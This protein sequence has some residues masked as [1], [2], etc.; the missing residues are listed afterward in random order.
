MKRKILFVVADIT[1]VGGIERVITTLANS[2]NTNKYEISI[3]S[4]Y[5]S[6][7]ACNYP[8]SETIEVQFLTDNNYSGR[9]G[10]MSR[11]VG[12]LKSISL[13]KRFFKKNK[14]DK[15]ISNSFPIT[16]CIVLSGV[17]DDILSYEHV[18]YGYYSNIVNLVRKIIYRKVSKIICLTDSDLSKYKSWHE[19]VIR[20]YNPSWLKSN[21]ISEKRFNRI[22]AVGRLEYQKGFDVLVRLFKEVDELG[23]KLDI[24]GVG[25]EKDELER[26][27]NQNNIKNIELKGK[28]NDIKEEYIKSDFLVMSSRFEGF[29]MVLVEAMECGLPCL[30]FDCPTGPS[31]II[32]HGFNGYLVKLGDERDFINR[33]IELSSNFELRNELGINA[34]KST[35]KFKIE[36]IIKQWES[37]LG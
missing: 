6:N 12:L 27:I 23:V 30:S 13:L 20:I 34:K 26:I 19:S 29:G 31:D 8:L 25:S 4:I 15:I 22:I 33:L 11:M 1:Y 35:E 16:S 28:T 3:L 2:F 7:G 24:Y 32:D 36:R 21:I 14:F 37:V 10:S 5:N 17:K 18:H 9:P